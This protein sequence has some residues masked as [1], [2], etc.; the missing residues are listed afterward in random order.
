MTTI[1]ANKRKKTGGRKKGTP[2][3]QRVPPVDHVGTDKQ[4]T[5][6]V[7]KEKETKTAKFFVTV[8]NHIKSK[9]ADKERARAHFLRYMVCDELGFD[10]ETEHSHMFLEVREKKTYAE[11]KNILL[12]NFEI[13]ANDIDTVKNEKH[14][15]T[16]LSK[17]DK[18]P[19]AYGI[20][21]DYYHV[22]YK[23]SK[24]AR[25]RKIDVLG[26]PYRSMPGNYIKRLREEHS[27]FWGDFYKGKEWEQSMEYK[28]DEL[29]LMICD[30]VEDKSK[31]GIYVFGPAG[32]G[33][34]TSIKAA[35]ATDYFEIN[36]K[37]QTFPLNSYNSEQHIIWDEFDPGVDFEMN[38]KLILDIAGKMCFNVERKHG[39]T[40]VHMLEEEGKLIMSSNMDPPDDP[41]FKRRFTIIEVSNKGKPTMIQS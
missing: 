11:M 17:E 37:S 1:I 15:F 38:R 31:G 12:T 40:E 3:R 29:E 41:G 10:Q 14:C 20:D 5:P 22:N 33:K 36:G 27:A 4:A 23:T 16:Y 8:N 28:N 19:E 26:Y 2:N 35:L 34:T 18:D 21:K 13:T 24:I 32:T 25:K 6:A 7:G 9:M 30:T 39:Q